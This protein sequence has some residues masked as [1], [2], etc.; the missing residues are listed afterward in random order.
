[1]SAG[2]LARPE[3]PPNPVDPYS[4]QFT[5]PASN[6]LHHAPQE[7]HDDPL[8][9]PWALLATLLG[10]FGSVSPFACVC[11]RAC[12]VSTALSRIYYSGPSW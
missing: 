4:P 8:I 12:C 3:L 1:M 10:V 11:V 9:P 6:N 7:P 2:P 5:F